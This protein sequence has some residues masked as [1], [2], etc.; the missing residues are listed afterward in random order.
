MLQK[1]P[2]L[3]IESQHMPSRPMPTASYMKKN[4]TEFKSPASFGH[5]TNPQSN[6]IDNLN[7]T[8]EQ[9]SEEDK[10]YIIPL[11]II[12]PIEHAHP[13]VNASEED[14][15]IQR[16]FLKYKYLMLKTNDVNF[17]G[18]LD[19][20]KPERLKIAPS[21]LLLK[22]KPIALMP[23]PPKPS[24]PSMS[25]N[26][27]EPNLTESQER[28]LKVAAT[29]TTSVVPQE[30]KDVMFV[31]DDGLKFKAIG[32]DTVSVDSKDFVNIVP[33]RDDVDVSDLEAE[34]NVPL[35]QQP[36]VGGYIE[37]SAS[38]ALGY[39]R[40]LAPWLTFTF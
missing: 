18:H 21:T 27:T 1:T 3:Q 24:E 12:L 33:V 19:N 25:S 40:K 39:Y 35:K 15:E 6:Y 7:V 16:H 22:Q 31:G 2:F 17:H 38:N 5:S 23:P 30:K 29:A 11:K 28:K 36:P 34:R 8:V 14:N 13:I 4:R 37:P 20:D 10:A 9:S 26:L 32:D